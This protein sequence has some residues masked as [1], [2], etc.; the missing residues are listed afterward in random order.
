L[1]PWQLVERSQPSGISPRRDLCVGF[2]GQMHGAVMAGRSRRSRPPGADFGAT[3]A[4]KKQARELDQLFGPGRLIELTLNPAAITK[5]QHSPN[6][7]VVRE[8]EPEE[9][10]KRVRH[11]HAAERITSAFVLTGERATVTVAD[12]SGTLLLDV[13]KRVLVHRKF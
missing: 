6:Y 8:N 10:W 3:S 1:R 2:S 9:H 12:A 11:I 5:F 13:A 7:T 4:L